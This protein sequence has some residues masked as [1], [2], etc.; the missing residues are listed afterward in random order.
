[1]SGGGGGGE[2]E[3]GG[4]VGGWVGVGVGG[5]RARGRGLTYAD[6]ALVQFATA[7]EAQGVL[8]ALPVVE[9]DEA[10]AARRLRVPVEPHDHPLHLAAP[11]EELVDLLR[12]G[13]GVTARARVRAALA[14]AGAGRLRWRRVG[15][16]DTPR[17]R[18]R[19]CVSPAQCGPTSTCSSVVKNERL[20]IYS[21]VEA[22][23][24]SCQASLP[25][26]N[27]RSA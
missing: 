21:V 1:V 4:W 11:R 19:M 27:L 22:S 23:S 7:D 12:V 24:A 6:D 3:V 2:G 17:G 18:C 15:R 9:L 14:Q 25:P 5:A 20:P 26:M 16:D 8:G 13:V 10:E